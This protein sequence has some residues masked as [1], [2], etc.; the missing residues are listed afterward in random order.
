VGLRTGVQRAV[1][2]ALGGQPRGAGDAAR[3]EAR[4]AGGAAR[5]ERKGG[6]RGGGGAYHGLDGQH[7]PL[8]G[9]PNEGKEREGEGSFSLPRSW[10]RGKGEWRRGACTGAVWARGPVGAA[11]RGR[12]MGKGTRAS[13]G[14]TP[15]FRRP[16]PSAI[17]MCARIKSHTYDDSWYNNECHIINI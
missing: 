8:S 2:G 3:R 6:D 9:D 10:V 13:K 7:K 14:V 5:R 17:H 1:G 15:G 11:R 16:N 12:T 4:Q